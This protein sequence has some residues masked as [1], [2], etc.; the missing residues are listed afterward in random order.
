MI[1]QNV[2]TVLHFNINCFNLLQWHQ[3]NII[4]IIT[5]KSES[6]GSYCTNNDNGNVNN[7]HL[8]NKMSV[9]HFQKVGE[10]LQQWWHKW[11]NFDDSEPNYF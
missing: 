4:H 11:L 10:L 5:K 8:N 9:L 6:I 7:G 2:N 3:S 1:N